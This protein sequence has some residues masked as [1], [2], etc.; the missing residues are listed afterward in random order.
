[1]RG[2]SAADGMDGPNETDGENDPCVGC[3][4]PALTLPGLSPWRR[5]G[6][7]RC[8]DFAWDQVPWRESRGTSWGGTREEARQQIS[9][10]I[11]CSTLDWLTSAAIPDK[12]ETGATRFHLAGARASRVRGGGTRGR[13][14]DDGLAEVPDETPQA[15]RI[16]EMEQALRVVERT[17]LELPPRCRQVFLL[18]TSHE[19]SYD[20]IAERLGVSKRTV[21]REMQA[22]LDAC[23]RELRGG[24]PP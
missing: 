5:G 1:M 12:D 11:G 4:S 8:D 15:E 14:D 2:S 7:V 22:A 17:L 10:K 3:G 24:E 16:V 23:Q 9:D 19:W 6:G 13:Q 21:E 20:A 18:R